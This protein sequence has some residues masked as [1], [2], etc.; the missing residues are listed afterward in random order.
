MTGTR[1]CELLKLKFSLFSLTFAFSIH[2]LINCHESINLSSVHINEQLFNHSFKV[3]TE[4]TEK[5]DQ[6]KI[7]D[8]TKY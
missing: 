2:Q 6:N 7:F 1:A 3:I 4:T 5:K 8:A